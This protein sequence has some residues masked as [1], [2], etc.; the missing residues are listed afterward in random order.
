MINNEEISITIK[1]KRAIVATI[2]MINS[3]LAEKGQD[4]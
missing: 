2:K 3:A 1:V 4:E